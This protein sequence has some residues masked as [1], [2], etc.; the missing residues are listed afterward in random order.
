[1][2]SKMKENELAMVEN[3]ATYIDY[4][5]R[6]KLIAVSLFTWEGLDDV[7]GNNNYLEECL[8]EKGRAVFLQD[9]EY[10]YMSV[11]VNPADRLNYYNLPLK[12]QAW[13]TGYS[14]IFDY[15]KVVYIRNNIL[16]IP[17]SRTIS[18]FAWRLYDTE[19]TIDVNRSAQKTPVLLETTPD[20][21]LTLKNVYMNYSGNTPVIFGNKKFDLGNQIKTLNTMAPYLIDKLEDHKH[22]IWNE[23]LTYLGIN[24][25]NTDKKERLI[26]DEVNANNDLIRYY[27][28]CFY[29][30]RKVACDEI[31]KKFFNGEE[32]IRVTLNDDVLDLLRL[33]ESEI[34]D[35][36]GEDNEDRQKEVLGYEEE[37][38]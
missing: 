14:K 21:L 9:D 24:N 26:T 17:T 23:A 1:M 8:F 3:N 16:E 4:F 34:V 11:N 30:T 33:S 28:N 18:L 31:N 32:K 10:G 13:S 20:T 25:A 27:L 38:G 2:G 5:E 7:G 36:D 12:V 35:Y 29:K 15:D 19:R 37:V 22:N 6:L